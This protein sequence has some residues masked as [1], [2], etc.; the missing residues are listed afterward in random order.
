MPPAQ[1]L[2]RQGCLRRAAL[3]AD[4]VILTARVADYPSM[5]AAQS[6]MAAG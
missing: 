2:R 5:A 3:D 4:Q 6:A 1:E